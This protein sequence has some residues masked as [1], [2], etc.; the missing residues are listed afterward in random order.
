MKRL[1]V[2]LL[3]VPLWATTYNAADCQQATVAALAAS[4]ADGDTIH[5]PVTG[6]PCTWTSGLTVTGKGI[7]I[8][9]IGNPTIIDSVSGRLLTFQPTYGNSL[10]RFSGFTVQP[11][12]T[13]GSPV[14]L[15]GTCMSGGC[16]NVRIDH[17]SFLGWSQVG[18]SLEAYALF[19]VGNVFGVMDHNIV[20]S[21]GNYLEF[22]NVNH[23]SY[24]G[25][26]SLGDN[27]WA[28]PNSLG[29][30]NA[31]FLEDNTF[32]NGAW[33]TDC[34]HMPN[35]YDSSG[36]RMV[37]RYNN[38]TAI[39]NGP[40]AVQNHGTESGG[41][42]R[43]GVSMEVYGNTMT[44][45]QALSGYVG[46]RSGTAMIWGNTLAISGSS[47]NFVNLSLYRMN[48]TR[49]S[50][51]HF[52][53][54]YTCDGTSLWDQNDNGGAA[55]DHGTYSGGVFTSLGIGGWSAH[56]WQG[57]AGSPYSV[58]NVTQGWG[59]EIV[60]NTST[61]LTVNGMPFLDWGNQGLGTVS[62]ADGDSWEIRRA[63]V[64]LDQPGRGGPSTLLSGDSD[65]LPHGWVGQALLPI[66]E[67]NDTQTGGSTNPVTAQ[68]LRII[69]NRD[70]YAEEVNQAAQTSKL[71][72]FDGSTTIGMGHGTFAFR[73]DTCTTGVG[74]WA[75]NQSTLYK[76]ASTN[77]WAVNYKPYTYPHPLTRSGVPSFGLSGGVYVSGGVGQ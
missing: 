34:D 14:L 37:V 76:C 54:W 73:P 15:R 36:C 41:R 77:V 49:A 68:S 26:G 52:W 71:F 16:P 23:G 13:S 50:D 5:V 64:C 8:I 55:Y 59:T 7:S 35:L 53:P 9:G 28:A 65:P 40:G 48:N 44:A 45:S 42:M 63:L 70:Y 2:F 75:T 31:L 11:G 66:Y 29:T 56:Q 72:P 61:G 57:A 62:W 3:G 6:S 10:M 46:I 20:T 25:V 33:A 4:A 43:G 30:A 39:I 47:S 67:W 18:Q 51:T 32:N 17:N 60:D 74:Y 1:L 22:A 58:R 24:L 19:L 69:R 21:G 27:S 12:T 38:F